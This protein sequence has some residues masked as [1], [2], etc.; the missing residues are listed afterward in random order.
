MKLLIVVTMASKYDATSIENGCLQIQL[1]LKSA[2]PRKLT[3]SL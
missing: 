2:V 1:R 3:F